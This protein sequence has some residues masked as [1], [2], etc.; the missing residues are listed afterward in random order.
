MIE[1]LNSILYESK[2]FVLRLF[3]VISGLATGAA[4]GL[5]IYENGVLLD[6]ATSI[7][8]H[9]WYDLIF[10]FYAINFF[11]KFLYSFERMEYFKSNFFEGILVSIIVL[12]EANT[13]F[14]DYHFVEEAFKMIHVDH[15]YRYYRIFISFSMIY[16]I[17][18]KFIKASNYITTLALKPATTFILSFFVLIGAG[19]GLLMMPQ[20]STIEGGAPFTVALYT[21]VSASCVTGLSLV[22]VSQFYSNKGHWIILVLMQFGGIGIVSFASFFGTFMKGGVGI[23]QQVAIQDFMNADSLSSAKGLLRQVIIITVLIEMIAI[24]IIYFSWGNKLIFE[25]FNQKLFY[26]VFHGVSA[27]CNA[28][29]SLFTNG[30][31]E[32]PI[33][34]SYLLHV[35]I[36]CTIFMGSLGFS[37]IQDLF[38]PKNLR[39]RLARPWKDWKLSTKISLY[40]SVALVA[41]G[42]I[43][44]YISEYDQISQMKT[45]KGTTNYV[46][47]VVACFFQ[48]MTTRTAGFNTMDF[49]TFKVPTYIFMIFLMFIGAS[50]GSTGGGIKTSTFLLITSSSWATIRGK[51]TVSL[52]KRSISNDLLFKAFSIFVFAASFNLA[53]IFFL[54]ISESANLTARNFTLVELVFEQIS[55][56][57]TVGL[58]AGIT[59]TLSEFGNYLIIIS[60]FV[61]RIGTLT[62]ALALSSRVSTNAYR[63]PS[64]H[65]MI[66]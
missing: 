65:I 44:F 36:G 54:S 57:A 4:F 6:T 39:E 11:I 7:R 12:S 26:S 22:D 47:Q 32:S 62:L 23:K 10:V 24:T 50:S 29:F 28:G 56:F 33:R 59:S 2:G 13:H 31:Y 40:T 16:L 15:Y 25:S 63:Y 52:G 45:D 27:F 43:V 61:G 66:G 18:Q 46:G 41:I 64:A 1:I 53:M 34:H 49:S 58:S 37:T 20:M 5:L 3:K 55:A 51:N 38:S 60:M 9:E 21:S 35:A 17:G 19:T 48:S 30:L 14:F 8:I 42:M